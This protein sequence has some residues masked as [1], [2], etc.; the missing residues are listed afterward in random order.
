MNGIGAD[1]NEPGNRAEG[2][3]PPRP[4]PGKVPQRA[5]LE[6]LEKSYGVTTPRH[7]AG[8]ETRKA[9][10]RKRSGARRKCREIQQDLVTR[11]LPKFSLAAQVARRAILR[12]FWGKAPRRNETRPEQL[13]HAGS[14]CRKSDPPTPPTT[15][16]EKSDLGKIDIFLEHVVGVDTTQK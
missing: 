16:C 3:N 10:K 14:L 2:G 11:S 4:S 12:D 8:T 6:M 15:C 7:P 5:S 9:P 1:C 13:Q